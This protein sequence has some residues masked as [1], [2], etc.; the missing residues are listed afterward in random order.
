VVLAIT[1]YLHASA[2]SADKIR[3]L[4]PICRQFMTFRWLQSEFSEEEDRT[5]IIRTGSRGQSGVSGG[6]VD[7]ST[8]IGVWWA[9]GGALSGVP[10]KV[11]VAMCPPGARS[12]A[13]PEIK[14]VQALKGKT[15]AVFILVASRFGAG[16]KALRF[17]PRK[18]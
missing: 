10:I 5:E 17:G 14:S 1:A 3:I 13:R 8:G 18:I 16:R 2:H 12:V 4:R 15:V 11:V 6:E 9:I 7:Y